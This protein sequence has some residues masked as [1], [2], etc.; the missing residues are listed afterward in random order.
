MCSSVA[1]LP[2]ILDVFWSAREFCRVSQPWL[3]LELN[4]LVL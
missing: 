2:Q 1:A 4:K 3:D